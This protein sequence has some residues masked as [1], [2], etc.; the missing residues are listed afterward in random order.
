MASRLSKLVNHATE[1]AITLAR[2]GD[3][4]KPSMRKIV[5]FGK[6][7][8][9]KSTL[10][11]AIARKTNIRLHPL[12]LIEYEVGG[13]KVPEKVYLERHAE[14]L[15]Q[16]CWLIEGFGTLATFRQR[17]AEADT[18]IYVDR[19]MWQHCWWVA[20]RFVLSPFRKPEGWPDRSPMLR[21]TVTSWWNLY[22]GRK[23]WTC[24][25]RKKIESHA[26]EKNVYVISSDR[27][28]ARLMNDI[29]DFIQ[30]G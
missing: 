11:K 18:L 25:F 28:V 19:P 3:S 15:R 27:D 5:V 23:V 7:A 10:S 21:S 6:P 12:D 17:L 4:S 24:E 20:K 13:S 9:G 30:A 16:D 22:R 26:P 14:I 2:V 8:G 1:K 29:E